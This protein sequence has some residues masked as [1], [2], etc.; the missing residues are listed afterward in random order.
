M[1]SNPLAMSN[2]HKAVTSPLFALLAISSI[3]VCNAV[4][5]DR[6]FKYAD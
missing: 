1:V 5:V 6:F 3:I 2:V 4:E